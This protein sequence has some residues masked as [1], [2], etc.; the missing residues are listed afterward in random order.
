MKVMI[1]AVRFGDLGKAGRVEE[2][3]PITVDG[4]SLVL[5]E[6]L[7]KEGFPV[8]R[9]LSVIRVT[10]AGVSVVAKKGEQ[11]TCIKPDLGAT[12]TFSDF[13][14]RKPGSEV[15]LCSELVDVSQGML[16]KVSTQE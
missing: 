14:I 12:V 6:R 16:I 10:D 3:E 9:G 1:E 11:I 13:S 15:Y 8:I 4:V 2:I 5:R 7:I